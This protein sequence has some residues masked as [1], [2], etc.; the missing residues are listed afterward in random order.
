MRK[1]DGEVCK[2][3]VALV[4]VG[5]TDQKSTEQVLEDTT[6]RLDEIDAIIESS[7][8]TVLIWSDEPGWPVRFISKNISR[9]GYTQDDLMSGR[10][11]YSDI[12]HPDDVDRLNAE[13]RA[14][15]GK[16]IR[17]WHHEYRLMTRTGEIRWVD[18]R[19]IATRDSQGIVVR[20][21][22]VIFDI[23]DRKAAEV[24]L[25]QSEEKYRMLFD[26]A[27]DGIFI[28]GLDGRFI[29]LNMAAVASTGYSRYDLMAKTLK[30]IE[31]AD[32]TGRFEELRGTLEAIGEV[33]FESV[34][35]RNDGTELPIEINARLIE[36][37]GEP[38]V[39]AIAR[40]MTERKM[41]EDAL[42]TVM[43]SLEELESIVNASPAVV[44][45]WSFDGER[46]VQFVT[47]NV[48]QFG[49]SP[50]DLISS[51][52]SYSSIIMP[53]DRERILGELTEH[54]ENSAKEFTLE[55][56]ILTKDGRVCW[57]D[58]RTTARRGDKG[59]SDHHQ[60]IVVD[61]TARKQAEEAL[62]LANEKLSLMGSITRHDVMN[63]IG[64]IMGALTLM[65]D[66]KSD[67][68]R[69]N[70]LRLAR[71][72]SSTVIQ[73]LEFAGTYQKAGTKAPE[74]V[75]LRLDLAG[76]LNSIDLGDVIVKHDLGNIEIWADPMFEKVMFNLIDN[77]LRH[78]GNLKR[79]GIRAL[80]KGKRLLIL[81][82][83]D[84]MGVLPE[85]KELI[86]DNGYGRN[87]GLGMFL[88]RE[89]LS[90]TGIT[91]REVGEYGK[92]ARFEIVVPPG[93]FR[94]LGGAR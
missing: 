44:F 89:V 13:I 58:D 27:N 3:R 46:R 77:S 12:I 43:M 79:I 92:G 45:R 50:S 20:L 33:S 63:Q 34:L 74:W 90:M 16:K 10:L 70:H 83:D 31:R 75:H 19:T 85:S 8:V 39:L 86:F 49:Y 42:R 67:N 35:I 24:Q 81:Y 7:P 65:E 32:I 17:E 57:V 25:S 11:K 94:D 78:G 28:L 9:F 14:L 5:M 37:S 21:H 87:T 18:E 4:G 72:A 60:G 68:D 54:H 1:N 29:D 76:A 64:I 40:D 2:A 59:G 30:D 66:D 62:R 93:K 48:Q 6:S 22:G 55:Y 51:R 71:A 80:I 56:R 47:N 69:A 15:T 88:C 61:I 91:I 23:T 38:A 84:G 26:S 41:A 53:E 82:E 36:Y 73:Q 52:P